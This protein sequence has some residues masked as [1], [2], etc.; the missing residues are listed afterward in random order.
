MI[1]FLNFVTWSL[2]LNPTL[3]QIK[4]FNEIFSIDPEYVLESF[5][6]IKNQIDNKKSIII[7]EK[8]I[9]IFTFCFNYSSKLLNELVLAFT[10]K[11][12]LGIPLLV[13]DIELKVH[14][15]TNTIVIEYKLESKV[16]KQVNTYIC[17]TTMKIN[18]N[19]YAVNLNVESL[20]S[21]KLGEPCHSKA[22]EE[23]AFTFDFNYCPII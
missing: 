1:N 21:S 13:E 20:A 10:T 5:I 22:E 12:V 3:D 23:E 15:E 11:N 8:L 16:N 7:K 14:N 2:D 19:R 17:Q 4:E 18:K 6:N 9:T